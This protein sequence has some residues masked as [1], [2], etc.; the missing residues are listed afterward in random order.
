MR[1]F[2]I[3]PVIMAMTACATTNAPAPALQAAAA[4][5]TPAAKPGPQCWSGDEGKFFNAGE[6]AVISGINVECK[7]TSDGKAAQWMSSKH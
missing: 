1:A 3:L 5:A 7:P 2:F 4:P 6:K